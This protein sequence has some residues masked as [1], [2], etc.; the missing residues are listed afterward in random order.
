MLEQ[1]NW[2]RHI[3]K[4][5]YDQMPSYYKF[6]KVCVSASW[7]ETTGLTSLEALFC[8]TNAVASGDRAKECLG[9]YASYCK[10]DDVLSIKEAIENEYYAPR[11]SIDEELK[12]TFT[13]KN[14]AEKTLVVYNNLLEQK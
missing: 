7:F 1:N 12:S 8:D 6:A 10:P 4:V 2:I 13:W 3:S 11:P 9:E 5:P 14:A